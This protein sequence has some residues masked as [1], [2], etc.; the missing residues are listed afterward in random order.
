M[1]IM[2][3]MFDVVDED[4]NVIGQAPRSECHKNPKLF[5]RSAAVLVFNSKGELLVHQRSMKKDTDPGKWSVSAWGH[6]DIGESYEHAAAR[7]MKEELGITP[8]IEFSFKCVIYEK[9]ETEMYCAYVT[10]SDGPFAPDPEEVTA[11]EFLSIHELK[12]Q[13]KESPKK[14]NKACH[15]LLNEYFKIIEGNDNHA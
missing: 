2:E 5:H 4:D 3:E 10:T 7:E 11:I 14:F 6:L 12:K 13:M 1:V 9:Y 8:K 15:D